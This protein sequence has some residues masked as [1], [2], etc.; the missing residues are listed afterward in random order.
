MSHIHD[1]NSWE[2]AESGGS[3]VPN[4]PGEFISVL[5]HLP[6]MHEAH[7]QSLVAA[8]KRI[9]GYPGIHSRSPPHKKQ[10]KLPVPRR[11]QQQTG[12]P[13]DLFPE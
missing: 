12:K 10:N 7:V 8:E 9:L 3:R 13:R 4:Q 11:Q 1:I 2:E 6:T 5:Q